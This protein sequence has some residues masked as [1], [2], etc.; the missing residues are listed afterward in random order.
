[1]NTTVL[2]R[3]IALTT[4]M[5]HLHA[6][7]RDDVA[8]RIEADLRCVLKVVGHD[9]DAILSESAAMIHD[10]AADTTDWLPRYRATAARLR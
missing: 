9:A 8:A 5:Q 7:G 1:M 6:R 2:P 10:I 3:I 4:A